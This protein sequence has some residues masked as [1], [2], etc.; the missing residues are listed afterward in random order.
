MSFLLQM[1]KKIND[2]KGLK[3]KLEWI[4]L[5]QEAVERQE[6]NYI[7]PETGYEVITEIGHLDRGHCCGS[8]CRHCPFDEN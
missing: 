6:K 4:K 1:A 8:G 3:L 5:H 7:D 2:I